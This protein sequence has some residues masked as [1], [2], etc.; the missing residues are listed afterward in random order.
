MTG[1]Q[2]SLDDPLAVE[3]G[4]TS[5]LFNGYLW[6]EG[7][8][9]TISF[10][11]SNN[12]GQGNFSRLVDSLEARGLVVHVPTPSGK[13]RHLLEHKGFEAK[14]IFYKELEDMVEIMARPEATK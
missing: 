7:N 1:E 6:L 5:D 4:F 14:H 11:V 12:P 2:I 8:V 3:V 13:M 9:V 10:I